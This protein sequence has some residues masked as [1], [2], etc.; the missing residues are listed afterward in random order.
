[1]A[2]HGPEII[3]ALRDKLANDSGRH[4]Y[5][6]VG[7]YRSLERFEQEDLPLARTPAGDP[8]PEPLNLNRELL[9]RIGDDDLKQ[10]VRDE[11]R[12]PLSVASR[13]TRELQTL[14]TE[15][16]GHGGF[17]IAKNVELLFAYDLDL[18]VFRGH[19]VNQ[20]HVLLLL[21]GEI[22]GD[23]LMLFHEAEPRFH[24]VVLDGLIAADHIW[25]LTDA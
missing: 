24:R 2:L 25:E 4:L 7:T 1:M 23:R 16:L 19:A 14:L 22:S 13:L 12:R 8:F 18:A 6:V 20:S 3:R 11:A 10:L 9:S 5:A 15:R 17:V 21:P